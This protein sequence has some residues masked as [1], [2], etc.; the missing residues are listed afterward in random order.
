MNNKQLLALYGLKYNPFLPDIPPQALWPPPRI[1]IFSFR[2]ENL[3]TDGGFELICGEPGLGK[4]KVIAAQFP[5]I[6]LNLDW[7]GCCDTTPTKKLTIGPVTKEDKKE[8]RRKRNE[9]RK[10]RKESP[11]NIS[12]IMSTLWGSFHKDFKVKTGDG[13]NHFGG[14]GEDVDQRERSITKRNYEWEIYLKNK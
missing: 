13:I 5:I 10:L 2:L 14:S 1:D 6:V 8:K 12:K 7:A 4:S 3:V 11:Y 9:M